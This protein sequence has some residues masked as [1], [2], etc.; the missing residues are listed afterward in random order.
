MG[1]VLVLFVC[2]FKLGQKPELHRKEN[3]TDRHLCSKGKAPERKSCVVPLDYGKK[4]T[5][6][7][8]LP[9]SELERN[10]LE[11]S[12]PQCTYHFIENVMLNISNAQKREV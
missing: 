6:D 7:A 4:N 1:L 5:A 2:I 11:T 8:N 12:A 10:F 9:W 3:I